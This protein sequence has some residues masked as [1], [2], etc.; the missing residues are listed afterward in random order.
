MQYIRWSVHEKSPREI[1]E[2]VPLAQKKACLLSAVRE[3]SSQPTLGQVGFARLSCNN[4]DAI[5]AIRCIHMLAHLTEDAR[6]TYSVARPCCN[7]NKAAKPATWPRTQRAW[8]M[9]CHSIHCPHQ[10][11][12]FNLLWDSVRLFSTPRLVVHSRQYFMA[13]SQTGNMENQVSDNR[14]NAKE[15]ILIKTSKVAR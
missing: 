3:L 10:I 9:L 6:H 13:R 15:N 11:R 12:L 2:Q 7:T 8:R 5:Y 14:F 4:L 1:G